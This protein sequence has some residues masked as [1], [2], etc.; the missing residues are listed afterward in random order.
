MFSVRLIGTG[1]KALEPCDQGAGP[2]PATLPPPPAPAPVRAFIEARW[3][4]AVGSLKLFEIR[5]F[6]MD[7]RSL[8]KARNIWKHHLLVCTSAMSHP[9]NHVLQSYMLSNSRAICSLRLGSQRLSFVFQSYMLSHSRAICSLCLGSQRLS[10]CLRY[11]R[12]CVLSYTLGRWRAIF[13][14][15]FEL[16]G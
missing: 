5:C 13:A 4:S 1:P 3:A 14:D 8:N 12:M 15:L 16:Y 9:R 2:H 10:L 11:M 7:K 6:Y